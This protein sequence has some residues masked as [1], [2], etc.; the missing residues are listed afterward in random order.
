[1]QPEGICPV[2]FPFFPIC[3]VRT[4]C[5]CAGNAAAQYRQIGRQCLIGKKFAG[6]LY[7]FA[8]GC[9]KKVLLAD[10]FGGGAGMAMWQAVRLTD[11]RLVMR[12][13]TLQLYLD[14][15]RL[16]RYW[17]GIAHMLGMELP[18]NFADSPTRRQHH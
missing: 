17:A 15:Q 10:T 11:A 1:M 12:V 9:Q 3:V 8:L 14:F 7:L 4:D 13:Y 6:G 2:R 18:V 16:L 5:Q